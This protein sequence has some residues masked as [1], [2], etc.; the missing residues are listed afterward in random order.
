MKQTKAAKQ[1]A[2]DF[3][4][5]LENRLHDAAPPPMDL[6][7]MVDAVW[8]KPKH[9]KTE[10]EK[11][12]SKE[13]IPFFSFAI[14]QIFELGKAQASLSDTEM[15]KALRCVYYRKFPEFS[16]SNVF[17]KSGYPFSKKWGLSTE[18]VMRSWQKP[19]SGTPANQA[20]PEAG[21]ATPFPWGILFEA[22]YFEGENLRAAEASLVS[23]VYETAFYRGLPDDADWSYDF[24][25]LLAYDVSE[26]GYLKQAWEAVADKKLFWEHGHLFVM[27]VRSSQ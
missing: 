6:K 26:D 8:R 2:Y 27:I 3:L 14:P 11:I 12:E 15:R 22:K 23:G 20:W 21:L 13:N 18:E 24:G 4:K 19:Q 7:S 1:A 10:R 9:L 16:A 17:R 5:Q 25:C